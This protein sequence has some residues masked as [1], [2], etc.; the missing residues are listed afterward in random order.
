METFIRPIWEKHVKAPKKK[1]KHQQKKQ[2]KLLKFP[3]D[4]HK[5]TGLNQLCF[6]D[7]GTDASIAGNNWNNGFLIRHGYIIQKSDPKGTF[8]FR[9]SLKHT[10]GFCDD[11]EK[12]VYGFEHQ[13]TLVRKGDNDDDFQN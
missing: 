10:F 6:K 11:Y 3:D 7:S 8:S 1:A 9:V 4:F 12:V 13:L 2:K 5:S